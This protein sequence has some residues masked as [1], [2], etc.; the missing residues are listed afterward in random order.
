MKGH[1]RDHIFWIIVALVSLLHLDFWAWDKIHPLVFGWIPYHLWYDGL[2]TLGGSL[3]FFWW[4]N[5][6]WPNP[7]AELEK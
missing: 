3:F 4:G 2:L 7:P 6:M 5:K 1:A